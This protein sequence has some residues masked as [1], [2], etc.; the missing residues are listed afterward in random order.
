MKRL[1][2]FPIPP[3]YFS[4]QNIFLFAFIL[5]FSFLLVPTHPICTD[6]TTWNSHANFS[7]Q[8]IH[9]L[10]MIS[11]FLRMA[12]LLSSKTNPFII[13]QDYLCFF[14][15][16]IFMYLASFCFQFLFTI[17]VVDLFNSC[18]DESKVII[19]F[20]LFILSPFSQ[21]VSF[22]CNLTWIICR[23]NSSSIFDM[24]SQC[25]I[26]DVKYL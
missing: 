14:C 25:S 6:L 1:R 18:C 17:S 22:S 23:E 24:P 9:L 15:I 10:S 20:Y 7:T 13:S 19:L 5:N 3:N 4:N 21:C 11:Y 2:T 8:D 12:F 16:C 26:C